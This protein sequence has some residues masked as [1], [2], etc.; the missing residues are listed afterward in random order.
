MEVWLWLALGYGLGGVAMWGCLFAVARIEGVGGMI[1][2]M[3]SGIG[4]PTAALGVFLLL[5]WLAV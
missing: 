4:P 1:T 2:V 5:A 3:T